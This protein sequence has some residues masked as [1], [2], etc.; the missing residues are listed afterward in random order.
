MPARARTPSTPTAGTQENS[1]GSITVAAAISFN[2]VTSVT[3]ASLP[4]GLVIT[5][6]GGPL[7]LASQNNTDALATGDGEAG[8]SNATAVIGAGVALNHAT[9]TNTANLGAGST[10][11]ADGVTLSA[12]V[13][14]VDT[15]GGTNTNCSVSTTDCRHSFEADGISAANLTGTL[16][17]AG[18]VGINLVTLTTSAQALSDNGANPATIHAGTTVPPATSR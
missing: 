16:G 13:R 14:P 8:A 4:S 9:M 6:T 2:L 10:V 7:T 1:G 3:D 5:V 11:T 18:A 17:V 12:T 15:T